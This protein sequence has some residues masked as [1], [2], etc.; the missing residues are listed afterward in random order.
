MERKVCDGYFE[1]T[2]Y[3]DKPLKYCPYG[4]C[5]TI[6][7]SNGNVYLKSYSTFVLCLTSEGW[8]Q[9]SGIYSRTT[10]KHIGAW[11]KEYAP[12]VSYYTAKQCYTEGKAYNIH[13]GEFKDLE[14]ILNPDIYGFYSVA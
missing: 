9:C 8:L 11:L 10:I 5:G 4:S 12:G 2:V 3:Y 6:E 13:T 7:R 1:R 14:N